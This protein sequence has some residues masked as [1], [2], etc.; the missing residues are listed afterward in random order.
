VLIK[1]S[2]AGQSWKGK[3]GALSENTR[4]RL[5]KELSWLEYGQKKL[6]TVDGTFFGS[7]VHPLPACLIS[8]T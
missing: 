8:G 4:G 5:G 1:C 7:L 6:L 3:I 2:R